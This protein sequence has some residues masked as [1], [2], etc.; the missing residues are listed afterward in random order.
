MLALLAENRRLLCIDESWCPYLDFRRRKWAP[1]ST[2]NTKAD[3]DLAQNIN[4]ICGLDTRGHT[5]IAL[6]RTNTNESVI[7]TYLTKLVAI[8]TK[9]DP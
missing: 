6:T 8:L 7:V 3:K 9:V 1:R 4:I 2:K 5:Y